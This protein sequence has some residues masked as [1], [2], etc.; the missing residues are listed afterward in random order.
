VYRAVAAL[1]RYLVLGAVILFAATACGN[2][3]GED[4]IGTS[5]SSR[6][7]VP[8]SRAVQLAAISEGQYTKR[9]T[10][11]GGS[12]AT[13][14]EWVSFDL[15]NEFIDRRIGISDAP[16]QAG[17]ATREDPSL[18]FLYM[19]SRILMWN[20]SVEESCGTP[21]IEMPADQLE[22]LTGLPIESDDLFVIEPLDI[23]R[24]A[25]PPR[26][27]LEDDADGTVYEI[28]VPG[29]TGISVSSFLAENPDLVEVIDKV[30]QTARVRIPGDHGPIVIE[31]D[32]TEVLEAIQPGATAGGD[33]IVT[34]SVSGPSEVT[35]VKLPAE[36]A[37]SSC[38]Q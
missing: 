21:W 14:V 8:W 37:G 33:A 27:P 11:S 2:G 28:D 30:E 38:L 32:L 6:D 3:P 22:Q 9:V 4:D 10:L 5:D 25:N 23:L 34:W 31:V 16:G 36:I 1:S 20:P 26:E 18:R 12:E 7:P 19:G 15:P 35:P 17:P 24:Q 13:T 29:G